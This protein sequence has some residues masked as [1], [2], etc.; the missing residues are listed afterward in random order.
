MW[1][2]GD[3]SA[4]S[5]TSGPGLGTVPE[6]SVQQPESAADVRCTGL[7]WTAEAAAFEDAVLLL[8]NDQR[9]RGA[10]CGARRHPA[11]SPLALSATLVCTA[12]AH[13][14]DMLEQDYFDHTSRD[15][16]SP[17]DRVVDAGYRFSTLG[18]NIASGQRTP[19]AVMDT[20]MQSTGHC[21]NIMSD[22]FVDVGIGYDTGGDRQHIWTQNFG[23]PL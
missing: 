21:E 14:R 1:S 12:R 19:E 17:G 15:G 6:G 16:R 18:E 13:S 8:V 2:C 5:D 10:T 3:D 4:D 22:A 7:A 20:W 23:R 11:A 9:E